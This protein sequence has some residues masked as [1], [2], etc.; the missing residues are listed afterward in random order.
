MA[1]AVRERT[2]Q[3]GLNSGSTE[4]STRLRAQNFYGRHG[5]DFDIP[6]FSGLRVP[7]VTLAVL[8]DTQ[9]PSGSNFVEYEATVNGRKELMAQVNFRLSQ[10]SQDGFAFFEIPI[11]AVDGEGNLLIDV[12]G[13]LYAQFA[14][15]KVRSADKAINM[16]RGRATLQV[17]VNV[18]DFVDGRAQ[19]DL[20]RI[21]LFSKS[22]TDGNPCFRN[23]TFSEWIPSAGMRSGVTLQGCRD[24]TVG[25]EAPN[26]LNLP[27][28]PYRLPAEYV[29]RTNRIL[30]GQN[31]NQVAL[32]DQ[33][34]RDAI[35]PSLDPSGLSLQR[36]QAQSTSGEIARLI[37]GF[38]PIVGD[39][40]DG[41]EQLYNA[42]TSRQVDPVLA[43]LS[44]AGLALDLG[45]GGLGDVTAGV[46][47]AYRVSLSLTSRGGVV[48]A[49]IRAEFVR[50]SSGRVSPRALVG[51]LHQRFV[52]IVDLARA[53]GCGGFALSNACLTRYDRIAT[54][55]RSQQGLDSTAALNKVDT[56]LG[57][58]RS[59]TSFVPFQFSYTKVALTCTR[60]AAGQNVTIQSVFCDGV[61][62]AHVFEGEIKGPVGNPRIVGL[63]YF[64][65]GTLASTY[66]ASVT[67]V[68]R[69]RGG[70]YAAKVKLTDPRSGREWDKRDGCSAPLF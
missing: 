5:L 57:S 28:Y 16:V 13:I 19:F 2:L 34:L 26:G 1:C 24:V 35:E 25:H 68:E 58:V 7:R 37:L 45:T 29:S 15:A 12:S 49:V 23:I 30:V 47:F 54:V 22:R 8:P 61:N 14:D 27:T 70:F 69:Y 59:K 41:L 53:R 51:A 46:K 66:R 40:V 63:H 60:R 11:Y 36:V 17:A 4:V 42:A 55:V 33:N 44:A 43:V 65:D 62:L 39:A 64:G 21:R 56:T 50:F 9:Y 67:V 6:V 48:A 10:V 20:T 31:L 3:F 38:I 32:Y 52:R 18:N